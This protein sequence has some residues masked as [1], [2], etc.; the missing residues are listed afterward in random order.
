MTKTLLAATVALASLAGATANAASITVSQFDI[1]EFNTR[2]AGGVIEDFETYGGG[3][4]NDATVTNV[5]MFRTLGG[6][7]SGTTCVAIEGSPCTTLA[8]QDS[9]P[10]SE[11]GVGEINGQGNLVPLNGTRSLSSADTLGLVWTVATRANS[12]F[13]GVVFA[14]RDVADISGTIFTITAGDAT[15][16]L[17]AQANNNKKLVVIDFGGAFSD[18]SI[19]MQ[20]ARNDAFTIDGATINPAPVPLPAA[21][22][23]LVGGLGALGAL[24]KRKI[25]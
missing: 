1:A 17:T 16:T 6:S 7:G 3:A 4:W 14:L 11:G 15:R 25:E 9:A 8:I 2:A 20:T 19:K 12:L 5:G 22:L 13:T 21:G 23:L 18:A 24:R 10:R